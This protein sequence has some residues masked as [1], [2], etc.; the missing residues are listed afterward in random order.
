MARRLSRWSIATIAK[1]PPGRAI[2]SRVG[3]PVVAVIVLL[4][5]RERRRTRPRRIARASAGRGPRAP[6]EVR[7]R[8]A[9]AAPRAGALLATLREGRLRRRPARPPWSNG[10]A[11]RRPGP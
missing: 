2:A 11:P 7:C 10:R 5:E 9:R 1:P 6:G 3:V 8:E 4:P